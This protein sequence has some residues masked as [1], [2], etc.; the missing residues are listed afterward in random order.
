MAVPGAVYGVI[1]CG[2][3]SSAVVRGLA[4]VEEGKRPVGK[5]VLYNPTE[6][7]ARRLQAEVEGAVAVEVAAG[8]QAVVDASDWVFVGVLPKLVRPVLEPLSF[9]AGQTVV[10]MA[11]VVSTETLVELVAPA[12]LVRVCPLPPVALHAGTS[13]VSPPNAEVAAVFDLLGQ[14]V[15]V[16]PKQLNAM[17]SATALMG[18]FYALQ[19][20]AAG[21]LAAQGVSD[22]A[23]SAFIGSL[24][25]TIASD[26]KAAGAGHFD[27]LVAEQTPGG[28]NEQVIREMT[29]AGVYAQVDKSLSGVLAR[30]EG[31]KV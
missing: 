14:T 12:T 13:V 5:F 1:G 22:E 16:P 19:R 27:H 31:S 6:E 3:M 26:A 20:A 30:I 18:P 28:L 25:H 2:T 23:S 17:W 15:Q 9:R 29:E 4:R 10:S 21:W 8:N 11:A 24:F 7:K